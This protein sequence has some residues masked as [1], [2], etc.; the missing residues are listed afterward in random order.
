MKVHTI[1][2]QQKGIKSKKEKKKKKVKLGVQKVKTKLRH[3]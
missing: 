1:T 2:D 3:I